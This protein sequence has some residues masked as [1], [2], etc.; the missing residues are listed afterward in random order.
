MGF[1]GGDDAGEAIADA[2][3]KADLKDNQPLVNVAIINTQRII[4][5]FVIKVKTIVSA[6]VIEFE[7]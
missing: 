5:G 3:R 7:K 1:A 6:D 2:K 4:L